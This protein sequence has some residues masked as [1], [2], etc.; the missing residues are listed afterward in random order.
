MASTIRAFPKEKSLIKDEQESV[1]FN[2]VPYFLAKALAEI[3]VSAGLSCLFSGLVYPLAGLNPS[4][5]KFLRFMGIT[6]LCSVASQS[7]GMLVGSVSP[8]ADVALALFPPM[9]ILQIIFDGKNIANAN[10]PKA[11]RFLPNL[12]IIRW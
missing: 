6:S 8:S 3:P 5:S 10:A 2:T 1:L 7:V 9:V 12:S 4:I 11:L